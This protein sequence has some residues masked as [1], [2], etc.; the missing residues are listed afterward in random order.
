M[1]NGL[2]TFDSDSYWAPLGVKKSE[3]YKG[4]KII[5]L[6]ADLTACGHYRVM[7]PLRYMNM[8]GADCTWS[9][10]C[11]PQDLMDAD[12]IIAQRQNGRSV[13][14]LTLYE[15]MKYGKKV[16]YEI[17]DNLDAVLPTSPVYG[18]YHQGRDEL[19]VL[20]EIMSRCHGVTVSTEELASHYSSYNSNIT[21]VPNSIDFGIRDWTS[22]PPDKDPDT[23][24]VGWSG[25]STHRE[26]L[27]ILV[28]VIPELLRKYP[29]IRFGLYTSVELA[30]WAMMRFA[31]EA[32][33]RRMEFDSSRV[34]L[35]AP[36]SFREH[37]LGL[38]YFDISVAPIVGCSFNLSK[39]L[40]LDTKVSTPRGI[41]PIGELT[42]S[43]SVYTPTGWKKV[44]ATELQSRSEGLEIRTYRGYSLKLTKEHR[45]LVN[46][47][48][49]YA[50]DIKVGDFLTLNPL[51]IGQREYQRIP[52][53]LWETRHPRRNSNRIL[54]SS[55]DMVSLPEIV[56]D[57]TW[58]EL[59]GFIVGDGCINSG[60]MTI[61]CDSKDTD[62]LERVI[63]LFAQ[64]GLGSSIRDKYT[65]DKK[66]VGCKEVRSSSRRLVS[67]LE[68]LG[69]VTNHKRTPKVPEAILRSPKSV[70]RAFL[71]GY[72]ESDGT[73]G[74]S[75]ISVTSKDREL[76]ADCQLLLMAFGIPS[77]LTHDKSP[78]EYPNNNYYSLR[79]KRSSSDLYFK[80]VGFVSERKNKKLSEMADRSHSNAYTAETWKDK[81]TEILPIELDSVDI[82]VEGEQFVA[83]GIVSHN[84]PLKILEAGARA[85]PSVASRVAPYARLVREGEN[86]YLAGSPSE[87]LEKLSILIDDEEKR[88]G[89]GANIKKQVLE[90]YNLEI[91]YSKWYDA[92][93]E[94]LTRAATGERGHKEY[95]VSYGR[96][97]RNDKCPCGSG[98]KY[99]ACCYPAWG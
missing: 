84:S 32:K 69:V 52:F 65:F 61:T 19:K 39:C 22:M 12:L 86:G 15:V 87:W 23:L 41:I 4:L 92:W 64:L 96:V 36:R 47:E 49:V 10:V 37:P 76:L 28:P 88:R 91:N 50:K 85:I 73:V 71:R 89:I 31:L 44:L 33:A 21:V 38:G 3:K 94:L 54:P 82:Q 13:S 93:T 8:H 75:G 29:R 30:Q 42:D 66:L 51:E 97:G 35:I 26:D 14:E 60:G 70:I 45:L 55:E 34:F 48:W 99:K 40:S 79:L 25:G 78:K 18:V 58:G 5:G 68:L 11:R 6:V 20:A 95:N 62:V 16:I 77:R 27:E 59:L 90:E 1:I 2:R 74:K 24:V 98:K 56:I 63:K 17:D 43:D 57:E 46:D 80:E 83:A 9:Q 72:F 67:F 53:S 7:Q 81:V